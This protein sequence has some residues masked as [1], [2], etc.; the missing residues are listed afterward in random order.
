MAWATRRR[1]RDRGAFR[2][3]GAIR[4]S[5]IPAHPSPLEPER[6]VSLGRSVLQTEID[7]LARIRDRIG[8]SFLSA[9]EVLLGC[10]GRVVVS[11]MG[12]SG[13]VCGRLAVTLR[14]IASMRCWSPPGTGALWAF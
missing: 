2:R 14:T 3:D 8:A 9:V 4:M 11:G 1:G 5:Q 13:H 10:R 12:K 6:V 7:A